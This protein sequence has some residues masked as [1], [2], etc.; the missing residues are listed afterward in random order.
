MIFNSLLSFNVLPNRNGWR[1][2]FCYLIYTC[3]RAPVVRLVILYLELGLEFGKTNETPNNGITKEASDPTF[4]PALFSWFL[5]ALQQ[6]INYY[7]DAG[8]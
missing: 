5:V 1:L 4:Y 3:F 7:Y 6:L 2:V 8:L